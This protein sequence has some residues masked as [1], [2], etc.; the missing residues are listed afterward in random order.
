MY[1]ANLIYMTLKNLKG[2]I[3]NCNPNFSTS[4]SNNPTYEL[5]HGSNY[6][7]S[8]LKKLPHQYLQDKQFKGMM[9]QVLTGPLIFISF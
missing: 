8:L 3:D 5:T 6:G 1:Q 2:K 4:S 9:W 7:L